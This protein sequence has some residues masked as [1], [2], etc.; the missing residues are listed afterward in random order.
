MEVLSKSV[1]S[2]LLLASV[3][4]TLLSMSFLGT[5]V[6]RPGGFLG[7]AAQY[8]ARSAAS[9]LSEE[10]SFWKQSRSLFATNEALSAELALL[11]GNASQLKELER[12]NILLRKQLG[13]KNRF[14]NE[15]ALAD[16]VGFSQDGSSSVVVVST[17][18]DSGVKVG[19][20]VVLG[21][22]LVGKVSG[23]ESA[24]SSVRLISDPSF[25]AA[26]LDQDSP[27]RARG[28]V[29]GVSSRE[30]QMEKILQKERVSSGDLVVSSGIDGKIPRGLILGEVTETVSS[31]GG[32]LKEAR[33][34]L[35]FDPTKLEEV[36]VLK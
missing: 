22:Y 5:V 35:L 24:R 36:F 4:L 8:A 21:N 7:G 15:L 13:L 30:L 32:I 33:M 14:K 27:D 2:R 10:R 31:E 18:S 11:R 34:R 16:V 3:C 6:E 29:R 17:G 19:D 20:L 9:W 12:E 26:A 1:I 23:V 28:V 25:S